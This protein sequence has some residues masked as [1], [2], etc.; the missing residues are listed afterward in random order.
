MR[1]YRTPASLTTALAGSFAAARAAA[2]ELARDDVDGDRDR[3]AQ[4]VRV[5]DFKLEILVHPL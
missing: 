5:D 1:E 2:L 4:S 3:S